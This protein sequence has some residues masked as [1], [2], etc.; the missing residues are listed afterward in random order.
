M[1]YLERVG[2][3][4]TVLT[5]G[6]LIDNTMADRLALH[7]RVV[8]ISLNGATKET[9]EAVNRGSRFERVLANIARLHSSRER[10]GAGMVISGRM[11]ITPENIHEIPMFLR[12]FGE[13]GF[14]RINF[15]FVK[16]TVPRF[17]AAHPDLW[18]RLSMQTAEAWSEG[19]TEA[20]DNL[21]LRQLG[22]LGPGG[23]G[24]P[25]GCLV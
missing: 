7:A 16:E 1:S 3:K 10:L 15:G 8:S 25:G 20:V 6:L 13:L 17:L 23:S 22:L 24:T 9:H 4:Y 21:R 18:S 12:N 14:D 19:R 11:T 2:R 5:N